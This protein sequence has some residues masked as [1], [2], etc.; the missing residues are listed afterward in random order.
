MAEGAWQYV[1]GCVVR[2]TPAEPPEAGLSVQG[3][4]TCRLADRKWDA[5][6]AVPP[7]PA[8]SAQ[9]TVGLRCSSPRGRDGGG[10]EWPEVLS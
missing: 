10:G 8:P 6:G 7:M 9:L 3:A 4:A 1:I 5:E 2:P